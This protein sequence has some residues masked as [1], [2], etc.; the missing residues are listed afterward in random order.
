MEPPIV[1]G[2]DLMKFLHLSPSPM[3]GRLLDALVELQWEGRISTQQ[4]ALDQAAKLLEQLKQ[5]SQKT[6]DR[7]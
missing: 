4:E 6:E 1:S 3:V 2:H 7:R 5:R